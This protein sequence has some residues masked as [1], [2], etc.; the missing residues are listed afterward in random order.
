MSFLGTPS[1]TRP[2]V[3]AMLGG[4]SERVSIVNQWQSTGTRRKRT[5]GVAKM[6]A[7]VVVIATAMAATMRRSRNSARCSMSESSLSRAETVIADSLEAERCLD[8]C[9]PE[10]D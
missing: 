1:Q 4:N 8:G 6:N 3:T 9:T 10:A 5:I 7:A 2:V